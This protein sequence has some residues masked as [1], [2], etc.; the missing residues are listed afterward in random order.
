[1]FIISNLPSGGKHDETK[2]TYLKQKKKY[3]KQQIYKLRRWFRTS[4]R[5]KS[6]FD[7]NLRHSHLTELTQKLLKLQYAYE[8]QQTLRKTFAAS[9]I[10]TT[11]H[12]IRWRDT[13]VASRQFRDESHTSTQSTTVILSLKFV[14]TCDDNQTQNSRWLLKHRCAKI[15]YNYSGT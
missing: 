13:L 5:I 7:C 1:M 14:S 4:L 2:R 10:G 6:T 9:P 15:Q 3:I 11:F 8:L 12:P